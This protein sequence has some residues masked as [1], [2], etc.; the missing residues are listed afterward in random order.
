MKNNNI[1]VITPFSMEAVL[2]YEK[3]KKSFKELLVYFFDKNLKLDGE[4][5]KDA[6]VIKPFYL[7]NAKVIIASDNHRNEIS[8]QLLDLGY[9]NASIVSLS[10]FDF[11]VCND[12][13][14]ASMVNLVDFKRIHTD[15]M[16]SKLKLIKKMKRMYD[17]A[18][19]DYTSID[20]ICGE[21]EYGFGRKEVLE[22]ASGEKHIFLKR[23]ELDVT[24]K[25]SMKCKYC[26]N[27]MQFYKKPSDIDKRTVISDFKRILGLVEWIDE[28]L[29]IGGEPLMYPDLSY[30]LNEI[31]KLGVEDKIGRIEL[32]TNGTIVPNAD[33]L[34]KLYKC[35]VMVSISNYGEKS[36]NLLQ[37]IKELCRFKI[38]YYVMDIPYWV[39]VEQ[40]VDAKRILSNEQL[41]NKRK[42]GC[43]T[44]H[45]VI[46]QGKF[47]LCCHIKSLDQLHAISDEAKECYINIYDCDAKE[48]IA[49]YLSV[50]KPLPK[51]CS[52][53]N[54][55][56]KTQWNENNRIS[57][58][59][60]VKTALEYTK[61]GD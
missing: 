3:L 8:K 34:D 40:Y 12:Y 6:Y 47:Y 32:V 59:E 51:A 14:A 17:I 44:L 43:C 28:V 46:D 1:V 21:G 27:M 36:K 49:K 53:C 2:I 48:Q 41:L 22:D 39:Y 19:F 57:V 52:W 11:D 16:G 54:G 35:N 7:C 9:D 24:S 45:R 37:L 26:S 10:D 23:L 50:D 42:E 55:N 29:I 18:A 15:Y 38:D 4:K 60:Q 13:E 31:E 58:A 61:Y 20:E 33:V 25:C 30:V 56:A 5:Y